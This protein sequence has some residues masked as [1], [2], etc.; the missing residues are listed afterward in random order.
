M[1]KNELTWED[2]QRLITIN[3]IYSCEMTHPAYKSKEYCEEVLRRFN[4]RK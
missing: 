4:E 3:E 1:N 2:V